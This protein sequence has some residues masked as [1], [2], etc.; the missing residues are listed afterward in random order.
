MQTVP[1]YETAVQSAESELYNMSII[2]GLCTSGNSENFG[3]V[4]LKM[5]SRLILE[6]HFMAERSVQLGS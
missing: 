5:V 6:W 4:V 2:N 3:S 1:Q